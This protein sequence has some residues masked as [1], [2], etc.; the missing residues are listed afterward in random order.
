MMK[1]SLLNRLVDAAEV[2]HKFVYFY[3]PF[4]GPYHA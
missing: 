4:L 1:L 2:Q 3:F